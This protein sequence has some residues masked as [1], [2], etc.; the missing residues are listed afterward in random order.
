MRNI[1]DTEKQAQ[2]RQRH[3]RRLRFMAGLRDAVTHHRA[4]LAVLLGYLLAAAL[5]WGNWEKILSPVSN[6]SIP[7]MVFRG[8]A[9][10]AALIVGA[11]VFVELIIALGTPRAA[12]KVQN[13]LWEAGFTNAAKIPPLLLSVYRWEHGWVYEFD[14]NNIS[15]LTWDEQDE[16]KKIGAAL[17]STVKKAVPSSRGNRILVYTISHSALPDKVYWDD[18]YLS[19]DSFV[20]VLGVGLSGHRETVNIA[21][22]PHI[23]LGGG[24]G[25]GKSVLMKCLL[26]QCIKK[27]GIVIIVDFKGGVDYTYIWHKRCKMVFTLQELMAVLAELTR[28][29]EERI[30]LFKAK[31]ARDIDEYNRITGANL[32]RYI[33]ACDEIAEVLDKTGLNKDEKEQYGKIVRDLSKIACK[34]RALGI[35]MFLSTQR[36]SAELIPGAIRTNLTL[37]IC[38]RADDILS[39][40]IL[41]NSTAADQVPL[42]AQGRFVTNTKQVFQGYLFDDSILDE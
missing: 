1:R 27:G 9:S 8:C 6:S 30:T 20:L 34:G 31:G 16:K 4:K 38:G 42:D 10:I 19:Q 13:D 14:Q 7:S 23:M 41:E 12:Y 2:A 3:I 25:S 5:V 21:S 17:K 35:H 22:M 36:P 24:S 32:Q 37:R 40:I 18:S 39:R 26:M 29:L 11:A 15:S 28:E 33:L